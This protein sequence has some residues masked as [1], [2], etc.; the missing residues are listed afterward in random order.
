M[1]NAVPRRLWRRVND[2]FRRS[3]QLYVD[4]P[5]GWSYRRKQR[6]MYRAFPRQADVLTQAAYLAKN[7]VN[8]QRYPDANKRTASVLLEVFLESHRYDRTCTHEGYA[9]FLQTVVGR[10]QGSIEYSVADAQLSPA[11][12][13]RY[14]ILL[15]PST[16]RSTRERIH[17]V[18]T[19]IQ[20][21][22]PETATKVLVLYRVSNGFA[23][24]AANVR[25]VAPPA[26]LDSRFDVQVRQSL[27]FL[28]FTTA[29]W[30]MRFLISSPS[31]AIVWPNSGA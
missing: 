12:D 5:R 11:T 26:G 6:A 2:H 24:A 16:L 30:E 27:P 22:V 28:D 3:G 18:S 20:A 14:L 9:A 13:V 19:S 31:S 10:I 21:D 29:R 23:H 4:A 8:L 17:D 15:A 1:A 25:E 7:L